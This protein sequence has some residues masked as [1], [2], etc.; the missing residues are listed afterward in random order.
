VDLDVVESKESLTIHLRLQ[1]VDSRPATFEFTGRVWRN[2]EL[3]R[4]EF[5]DGPFDLPGDEPRTVK[6][7]IDSLPDG[8]YQLTVGIRVDPGDW[9][10]AMRSMKHF[11][12]RNGKY[13]EY[14]DW[15]K[16]SEAAQR[17]PGW[18]GGR[19]S[20]GSPA[21]LGC[22]FPSGR[23]EE[24]IVKRVRVAMK[25]SAWYARAAHLTCKGLCGCGSLPLLQSPAK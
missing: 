3:A 13:V 24:A 7:T 9:V 25:A 5:H 1:A 14:D 18:K 12:I 19:W 22:R 2:G 4:P 8:Y 21:E 15:V 11:A 23:A 6:Y 16:W 17:D 20:S 10:R